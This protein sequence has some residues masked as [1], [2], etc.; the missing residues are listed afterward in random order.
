MTWLISHQRSDHRHQMNSS[1]TVPSLYFA[2]KCESLRDGSTHILM[3]KYSI[4]K[5][6]FTSQ[7]KLV[8]HVVYNYLC[9]LYVRTFQSPN[10]FG[11]ICDITRYHLIRR[12]NPYRRLSFEYCKDIIHLAFNGYL[13][14][15]NGTRDRY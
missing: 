9:S 14:C 12:N 8:I 1:L 4:I 15:L 13:S 3:V 2:F 10:S 7:M 11:R 5:M 6:S